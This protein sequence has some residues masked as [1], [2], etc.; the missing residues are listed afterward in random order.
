[1]S[2]WTFCAFAVAVGVISE[3]YRARLKTKVKISQA[4]QESEDIIG[5][6]DRMEQRIANLETIVIDREKHRE[7]DQSL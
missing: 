5:R 7:F 2:F 3:M 1:M 6:L 4:N